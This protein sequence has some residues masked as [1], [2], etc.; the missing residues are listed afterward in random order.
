MFGGGVLTS[1]SAATDLT[2]C[3]LP[4]YPYFIRTGWS[5]PRPHHALGQWACDQSYKTI[6]AIGYDKPELWNTVIKTY[7]A[8]SQ[9]W[10][11]GKATFLK[12]PGYSHDFPPRRYCE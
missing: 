4:Q 8:V 2:Q 9:F 10:T 3:D 7:P 12:Q 11:Y 1:V 6:V 5:S